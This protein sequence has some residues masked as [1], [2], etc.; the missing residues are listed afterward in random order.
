VVCP[1]SADGRRDDNNQELKLLKVCPEHGPR[2]LSQHCS[3]HVS[4]KSRVDNLEKSGASPQVVDYIKHGHKL[5]WIRKPS[6]FHHGTFKVPQ[7]QK[8]AWQDLKQ[9]YL[10]NGAIKQSKLA[11]V[12]PHVPS[13]FLRSLVVSGCVWIYGTS[14]STSENT[15]VVMR[16]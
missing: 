11:L 9:K 15:T 2:T 14:I 13:W 10:E 16:A 6:K 7:Q 8:E 1:Q 4:L 5:P 3:L 12:I